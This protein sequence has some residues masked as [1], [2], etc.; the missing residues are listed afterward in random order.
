VLVPD[1][2]ST[3]DKIAGTSLSVFQPAAP[4]PM[5]G[6]DVFFLPT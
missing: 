5:T 1:H 4:E 3:G 6:D 2:P